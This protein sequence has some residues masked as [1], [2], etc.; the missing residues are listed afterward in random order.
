[1]FYVVFVG[2]DGAKR[3]CLYCWGGLS[4]YS[5]TTAITGGNI[6]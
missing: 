4:R 1:M 5:Y 3:G 2:Y 6:H